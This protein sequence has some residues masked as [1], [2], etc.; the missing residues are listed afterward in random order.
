MDTIETINPFFEGNKTAIA[1]AASAEYAPYLAVYLESIKEHSTVKNFY[2]VVVFARNWSE[3]VKNVF[4]RYFM[5]RNFSVRFVNPENIIGKYHFEITA[6][7][8]ARE[9]YYRIVSPLCLKAY[10]RVLY[11]DVDLIVLADIADIFD[12]DIGDATIAACVEPIYLSL[13]KK[14]KVIA[15]VCLKDYTDKVLA[16][17]PSDYR[18]TGVLLIDVQKYIRLNAFERLIDLISKNHFVYQEQCAL[19]LLFKGK[20]ASISREWN[21]ELFHPYHLPCCPNYVISDVSKIK[22]L[23]FLGGN[24]PWNDATCKYGEVWWQ[25]ARRSPFYGDILGNFLAKKIIDEML[26]Q[27]R[28][29]ADK[30]LKQQASAMQ[31]AVMQ[32][33]RGDTS[34]ALRQQTSVMRNA[35]VQQ[36]RGDIDNVLKREI[37]AIRDIAML[38]ECL[39][40]LRRIRM[41][42]FFS[43]GKRRQRYLRRKL[44]LKSQI[45]AIDKYIRTSLER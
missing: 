36:V 11:T 38:P 44:E 9:C 18:N 42:I 45:K 34:K 43:W 20:I 15:D 16:I 23:H 31:N 39:R 19:N 33:V 2:D 28:S 1:C 41:K 14:K 37:A 35:V 27:V 22:I 13:Y 3:E 4:S 12:T 7:N 29:D 6:P 26:P 30:A 24:K 32:Q 17:D 40:K 21:Y 10:S 5:A 8:F 25:Y